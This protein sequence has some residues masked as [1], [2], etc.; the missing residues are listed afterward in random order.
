MALTD[1]HYAFIKLG[2]SRK[3]TTEVRFR[4]TAAQ[5][6]NYFSA[7]TQILKDATAVGQLLLSVEDL[8]AGT[9]Q[10][11]GVT[12]ITEDDAAGF[13]DFDSDIFSFDKLAVHYSA[14]FDNYQVTIP[15]R[16]SANYT[17]ESD[18]VHV[19]PTLGMVD[20][21]IARFNA[22][23]L[24]KNGVAAVVENITVPS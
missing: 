9:L 8:S 22:V 5:A 14:G 15:A 11:K 19:N 16:D 21:F 3:K 2:D 1:F 18:A 23:V 13:P 17:M 6:T 10:G 12:L 24:G 20:E 4:V 7:V